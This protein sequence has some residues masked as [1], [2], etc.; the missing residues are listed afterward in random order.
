MP[1]E[2]PECHSEISRLELLPRVCLSLSKARQS[3]QGGIFVA[4]LIC[5]PQ[6][7][8]DFNGSHKGHIV[9]L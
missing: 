5:T 8:H 2:I 6:H 4:P 7:C 1:I 9:D 3:C